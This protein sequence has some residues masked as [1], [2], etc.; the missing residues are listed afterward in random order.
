[1]CAPISVTATTVGGA[2]AAQAI[3][4]SQIIAVVVLGGI[5]SLNFFHPLR[6]K[7]LEKIEE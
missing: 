7:S 5:F 3:A 6:R 2:V 1:M 4:M